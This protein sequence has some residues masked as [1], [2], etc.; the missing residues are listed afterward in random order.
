MILRLTRSGARCTES[1][2]PLLYVLIDGNVAEPSVPVSF[3]VKSLAY[4]RLAG[5][6]GNS[7][8][9]EMVDTS[10]VS[11]FDRAEG[12]VA[13]WEVCRKRDHESFGSLTELKAR[14]GP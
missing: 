12:I 1:T 14:P 2:F 11:C 13:G 5:L 3:K 8:M 4:N 9:R 10:G 6:S 7:L